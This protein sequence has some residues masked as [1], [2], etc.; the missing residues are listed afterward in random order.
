MEVVET[1]TAPEKDYSY[2]IGGDDPIPETVALE[3]TTPAPAEKPVTEVAPV[4]ETPKVAEAPKVPKAPETAPTPTPEKPAEVTTVDWKA[5]LK[6]ADKWEALKEL[7]YD[8]F[9]IG[10]LKY[11]EK[12]GNVTPYLEVKT[13]D[14]SKMTPEQVLRL[15]LQKRNPGMSEKALNFK[16]NKELSEKYYLDR[17]E[18]PEESDEAIYG[19]EQLRLD[20]EQKRKDF[21]TEQEQFKA[22]EPTPDLDATKK[23][24]ELQQQRAA[25]GTSVMNNEATANLQKAK[26]ITFGQGEESFN[27]PIADAQSLVDIALNTILN[28]G[29]TDLA[30]VDLNAFYKQLAKGQPDW[31]EAFAKH[32]QAIGKKQVQTELQNVTPSNAQGADQP[33]ENLKDYG[34]KTR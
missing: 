1:T 27:Y 10:M 16:F 13:V 20:A 5:A 17:E 30:G 25:L 18:F 11:K 34:Y 23:A 29:R 2:R 19:Q 8:D 7:G 22:P 31:E 33:A 32:H 9:T 21:L 14:Y 4:T 6:T 28:S 24:A 26:A 3:I 12:T 15:D